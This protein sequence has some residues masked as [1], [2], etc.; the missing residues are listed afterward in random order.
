MVARR[1]LDLLP[2]VFQTETNK[3]FLNATMDQLIQEPIMTR[4][5]SY[6]GRAEGNPTYQAGDPYVK[7]GDSF[8]QFYQLEPSLIVRR[9][10]D[11]VDREYKI[12]NAYSLSLIHI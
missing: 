9:R 12:D 8:S 6:V 4:L 2:Q 11:G 1:T 7:E 10:I 3:R 5:S